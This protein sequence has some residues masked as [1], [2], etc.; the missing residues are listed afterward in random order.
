MYPQK[1]ENT[2][3][4]IYQCF[5]ESLIEETDRESSWYKPIV[6]NIINKFLFPKFIDGEELLLVEEEIGVLYKECVVEISLQSLKERGLIDMME[7]E[8]GEEMIF[9][10]EGGKIMGEN[11]DKKNK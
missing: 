11:V 5:E 1:V 2:S 3:K 7:N 4:E 6:I 8:D 9:L 10:T